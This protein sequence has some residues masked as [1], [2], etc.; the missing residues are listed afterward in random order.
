M[1]KASVIS[2]LS[3]FIC[4]FSSLSFAY[5]SASAPAPAPAPSSNQQMRFEVLGHVYCDTC[6]VEFET[7]ISEP[8]PGATVRLECRNRTDDKITYQSPETTAGDKGNYKI[9]V[10]GDYE[11]SDCDVML[12]KSPRADCND[13][14]EEWR[15]ARVVLTTLDGVSGEIRFANNLGFKKKE[16]L[17]E[18]TKVLTEMGYFEL[19]K[20]LGSE[21]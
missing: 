10:T 8:I 21:A 5:A 15:K 13:P 16:A 9:Q 4:I 20:E 7:S 19:Q 2:L 14:T 6:R 11:E 18:C 1:A 12:V 3:L 17:P